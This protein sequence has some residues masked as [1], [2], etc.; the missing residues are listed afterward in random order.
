MTESIALP[1]DI[2]GI[3]DDIDTLRTTETVVQAALS[4]FQVELDE[5]QQVH[6]ALSSLDQ[7]GMTNIKTT[8]AEYLQ[9]AE[10]RTDQMAADLDQ[11]YQATKDAIAKNNALLRYTDELRDYLDGVKRLD[12]SH[13]KTR[14]MEKIQ[15][16]QKLLVDENRLG[17]NAVVRYYDPSNTDTVILHAMVDSV[18]GT[19]VTFFSKTN[20]HLFATD[21]WEQHAT[22]LTETDKVHKLPDNNRQWRVAYASTTNANFVKKNKMTGL[23]NL[24]VH[25]SKG[26]V[27]LALYG[28][29]DIV[30]PG[31][32]LFLC[33]ALEDSPDIT[34][35][36]VLRMF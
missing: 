14:M 26:Y 12:L 25:K 16:I 9:S 4:A 18:D 3:L 33:M 10:S 1:R 5:E 8:I 30:A 29:V 15:Q 13:A 27:K 7:D 11:M 23:H 19:S 35:S 31:E 24:E 36:P 6:T 2:Q 22:L 32:E 28:L 34:R 17:K 20:P 21:V